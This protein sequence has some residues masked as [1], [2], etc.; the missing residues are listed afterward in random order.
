MNLQYLFKRFYLSLKNEGLFL[1]IKKVI[2]TILGSNKI[3]LDK[4]NLGENKSL[5]DLFLIFGTDKGK[6]DSKKTYHYLQSNSKN[7]KFKNYLE[8]INRKKIYDYEY[9]L[10]NNFSLIYEK[11]FSN[12]KEKNINFL[13]LGVANGHSLASW[14][15]Y[16]KKAKIYGIDIKKESKLFYKGDRLNYFSV[17]ITDN[18]EVKNF[19]NKSISFDVIIDDSLH[20]YQGFIS[21]L[22]NF[23]PIVSNG[24]IYILEDFVF[25]DKFKLEEREFNISKGH[26]IFEPVTMTMGEFFN[27]IKN[28]KFFKHSYLTDK[29]IEYIIQNTKDVVVEYTEHPF[30]SLGI[31]YKN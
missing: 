19:L 29:E 6:Y 12:I 24:G 15:M 5:D 22:K 3:D 8:F 28:K 13:E 27:N 9:Q 31:I 16:F 11:L 17:D 7:N 1:A 20:D 4:L 30:G 2:Y 10:G 14:Y 23:Y 25:S 21:N 26:K 18:K